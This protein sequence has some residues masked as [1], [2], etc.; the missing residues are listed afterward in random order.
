MLKADKNK[1]KE[2][3][4]ANKN[5][6]YIKQKGIIYN[7]VFCIRYFSADGSVIVVDFI[8]THLPNIEKKQENYWNSTEIS[9]IFTQFCDLQL[10][11]SQYITAYTDI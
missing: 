2:E 3:I 8:L 11:T 6:T 9:K 10:Y 7:L 4:K 1:E 5:S